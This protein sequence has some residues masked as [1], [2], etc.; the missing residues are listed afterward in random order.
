MT[1]K[2][3]FSGLYEGLYRSVICRGLFPRTGN[4]YRDRHI[5]IDREF[6]ALL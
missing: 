3:M 6:H 4:R 2:S 1:L 5:L